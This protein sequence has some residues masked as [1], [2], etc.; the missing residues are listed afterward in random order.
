M[1]PV[2]EILKIK[3]LYL[4]KEKFERHQGVALMYKRLGFGAVNAVVEIPRFDGYP[5]NI[6]KNIIIYKCYKYIKQPFK[7]TCFVAAVTS[8]SST[9]TLEKMLSP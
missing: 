6:K 1:E 4:N 9:T 2:I 3:D 8:P 5:G 7:S